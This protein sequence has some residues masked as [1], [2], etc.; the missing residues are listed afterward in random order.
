MTFKPVQAGKAYTGPFSRKCQ[1]HAERFYHGSWC[2]LD[3]RHGFMFPEEVIRKG[4]DACL[5]RPWTEPL[6]LGELQA[7]VK[8]RKLD[9]FDRITALGGSRF[10]ILVEDVFPGKRVRAPLAGIG[11]IGEMM[12]ALNE[13][14]ASGQRL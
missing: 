1:V 11:G 7:Q 6:T 12:R 9:R 3:P 2:I 8:R 13:S 10:I 5:F 4:H 14:L